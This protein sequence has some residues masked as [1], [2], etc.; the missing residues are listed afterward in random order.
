M[1][2]SYTWMCGCVRLTL[3]CLR[4][5]MDHIRPSDDIRVHVELNM[6]A[7]SDHRRDASG[8]V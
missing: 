5:E 6:N 3:T 8:F 2:P 1:D 7:V 4:E